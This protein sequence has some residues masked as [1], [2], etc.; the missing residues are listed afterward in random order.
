MKFVLARITLIF[1]L[2][3]L[4]AVALPAPR[5]AAVEQYKLTIE[6]AGDADATVQSW[7]LPDD[8]SKT[9][10][11]PDYRIV[12]AIR[13]G[14]AL[15]DGTKYLEGQFDAELS[16][17]SVTVDEG[18][19]I[20]LKGGFNFSPLYRKKSTND[21]WLGCDVVK[22]NGD[23][24]QTLQGDETVQ[25]YGELIDAPASVEVTRGSKPI[26]NNVDDDIGIYNPSGMEYEVEYT[27]TNTGTNSLSI[28]EILSTFKINTTVAYLGKDPKDPHDPK[29]LKVVDAFVLN[30]GE[31]RT[32][33]PAFT[34]Q[35]DGPFSFGIKISFAFADQGDYIFRAVGSSG[36][37]SDGSSD[38]ERTSNIIKNFM[39]R[40]ADQLTAN[41]PDLTGR[42]TSRG[43]GDLADGSFALTVD[44][45]TAQ[46]N[47]SA[48]T[49]LLRLMRQ[50]QPSPG[51]DSMS[52]LGFVG[53]PKGD[54]MN[55]PGVDPSLISP[56]VTH[57]QS[58]ATQSTGGNR[59]LAVPPA[60][61]ATPAT[62]ASSA[63][64]T[65]RSSPRPSSL[66]SSFIPSDEA[67]FPSFDIW[68]KTSFVRSNSGGNDGSLGLMFVGADYLVNEHTA[69]G[70]LT[71]FD[72]MEEKN[73]SENYS[74]DGIGW[75][76]GPYVVTR[77]Y[78][79]VIFDGRVAWGQ[80]Y[81]SIKPDGTYEDEFDTERWLVRGQL[82][83]RYQVGEFT[84]QPHV[85]ALY[86]EEQQQAYTN[87]ANEPIPAQTV[88]L[89]RLVFGPTVSYS[90]QTSD[91]MIVEPSLT[92]Q[93]L[94][95][96]DPADLVDIDDGSSYASAEDLRARVE[97]GMA[98]SM[99]TGYN[100]NLSAFYDGIG[101]DEVDSYGGSVSVRIP[102]N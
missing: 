74:V 66:Q 46:L 56:G 13:D 24:E 101:V 15:P 76:A 8:P 70:F 3:A 89:G 51:D 35:S 23:C 30:G 83:G 45:K 80:S 55:L 79:D 57:D 39:S 65:P 77:L 87:N 54:Q 48:A 63:R 25:Y 18:E 88:S 72:W 94:W 31:S 98:L 49:S 21:E 36:T 60:T 2:L 100:F 96:F 62:S 81:N 27:V 47:V 22:N 68:L 6:G 84:V 73:K 43:Q 44:G 97:A 14:V 28:T 32:F 40:R 33:S 69:F 67:G 59:D 41:D 17:C 38:T 52:T 93:G 12:C 102:L 85:R 37:S 19:T 78:D 86:F 90:H 1:G 9:W 20:T 10:L 42:L 4:L 53:S 61:P 91:G 75:M 58:V 50:P 16:I 99:G 5:A 34:P 11:E 26:D 95:D 82:T 71:Q 92:V 29:E 64:S 7:S